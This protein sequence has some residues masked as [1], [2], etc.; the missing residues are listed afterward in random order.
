MIRPKAKLRCAPALVVAASLLLPLAG[1]AGAGMA[2]ASAGAGVAMGTGVDYTL[3]GIA[4]KTFTAPIDEVKV[5]TRR[6]LD[7]M[8]I[9]ITKD[10]ASEKG[11]RFEAIANSREV[12]I[13]LQ[14]LTP[15]TTRIRVVAED[16]IFF[17][18]KA[19]ETEII[20]QTAD[21]L[22][23]PKPTQTAKK[24]PKPPVKPKVAPVKDA[25]R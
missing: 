4:F 5:A 6:G 11:W 10:E 17:K 14:E 13:E 19:T 2:V 20:F 7:N 12:G 22:D 23:H 21:A 9:E 25:S 1:C 24:P 15:K 18:D 8:G 16:G 3:N